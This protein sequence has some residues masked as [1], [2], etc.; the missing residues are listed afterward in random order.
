[1]KEE[2]DAKIVSD[3]SWEKYLAELIFWAGFLSLFKTH[4]FHGLIDF[5]KYQLPHHKIKFNI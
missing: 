5:M 1:M 2:K 3:F 4:L